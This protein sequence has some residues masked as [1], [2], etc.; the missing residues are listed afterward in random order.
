MPSELDPRPYKIYRSRPPGFLGRL[1]G[2]EDLAVPGGPGGPGDERPGRWG[3]SARGRIPGGWRG[4]LRPRRVL[5]Y[6][7]LACVAW[8]LLSLVLFIVST[9]QQQSIPADAQAALAPAGNML[10]STD[11]VLVLGTDQRPAGSKEP[12]ANTQDAGSRSDT[13]M[14]W[15]VGG[16][17]SRRLSIPRD[18]E[19]EIPGHGLTKINAA[20]AYGGPALAI[21]TIEQFTGVQINHVIIVNLAAFPPFIDALG[22]IDVKTGRVCSDISGGARNGGWSLYLAP[23]VHHLS[24]IQALVYARTRDNKCNPRENDLTR[25]AHQQDILNAIKA[26]LLSAGTFFRLPWAS[27]E[28]PKVL[29]TDMGGFTLL[30]LF[31]ASEMGGSAPVQVLEPTGAAV[32]PDGEDALTVTPGAVRAAVNRLMNG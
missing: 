13:I 12:G 6:L 5:A 14:L 26:K 32:L 30:S 16:G 8:L 29:R 17:V 20:Y 27:W 21:K 2:E 4:R 19:A 24:G 1:R 9:A 7:V 3:R 18:T 10:T 11:T 22:G 15:R 25:E 23:G 28:A 31:A